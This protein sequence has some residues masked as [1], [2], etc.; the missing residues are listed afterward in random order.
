MTTLFKHNTPFYSIMHYFVSKFFW[1]SIILA[2]L[3]SVYSLAQ[4]ST[5]TTE[6]LQESKPKKKIFP[7]HSATHYFVTHSNIPLKKDA[8][9]YRNTYLVLN[10]FEYGL[11]DKLTLMGGFEFI[12]TIINGNP[13]IYINPR[14]SFN[15]THNFY[16]GVGFYSV[17][18]LLKDRKS[19]PG[20]LSFPYLSLTYGSQN[21]NISFST[22]LPIENLY[23]PK[24]TESSNFLVFGISGMTRVLKSVAFISE[25]IIYSGEGITSINGIRLLASK[26]HLDLALMYNSF[27]EDDY[28]FDIIA[29]FP[30]LA[31]GYKFG[32]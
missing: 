21:H 31:F 1:L 3:T 17:L 11:T 22:G 14:Y 8:V 23:K 4:T 12:S 15:P 10:H 27:L 6:A 25:N 18:P 28:Y 20:D 16:I 29:V 2:C 13:S 7:N 24:Y 26:I 30:Y 5:N 9:Y 19:D 32:N